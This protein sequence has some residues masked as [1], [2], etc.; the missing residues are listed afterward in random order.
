MLNKNSTYLFIILSS[1]IVFLIFEVSSVKLFAKTTL[2]EP[3]TSINIFGDT[4]PTEDMKMTLI[5]S[6]ESLKNMH[7]KEFTGYSDDEIKSISTRYLKELD[8]QRII[9]TDSEYGS[10]LSMSDK[11]KNEIM[12][13]NM[14]FAYSA[15]SLIEKKRRK[16]MH[17]TQLKINNLTKSDIEFG[18]EIIIR[19]QEDP[20]FTTDEQLKEYWFDRYQLSLIKLMAEGT[21]FDD[22]LEQTKILVSNQMKYLKTPSSMEVFDLYFNTL[23]SE[24]EAHTY[25]QSPQTEEN[26]N[27]EMRNELRGVGAVLRVEDY[28]VN[29]ESLVQG[30]PAEKSGLLLQDDR[31]IEVKHD[32][33]WVPVTGMRLNDVTSM[34]KGKPGTYAEMK[35]ARDGNPISELEV[36]KIKRDII[37]VSSM[38]LK[39]KS[40]IYSDNTYLTKNK[41]GVISIPQFYSGLTEDVL[42]MLKDLVDKGAE[43]I[44]L[45]LSNNGGGLLT[46][47]QGVASLFLDGGAI[48]Y[49]KSAKPWVTTYSDIKGDME[50]RGP[51]GIII[52]RNSASASEIVAGAIQ[53]HKRGIIL[54]ET[55]FGKG[56]VQNIYPLENIAN[57]FWIASENLGGLAMTHS[58]FYR[59]NG[60]STQMSGVS[61]D[62]FLFKHDSHKW[63]ESTYHSAIANETLPLKSSSF[64]PAHD[65]KPDNETLLKLQKKIDKAVSADPILIAFN[66]EISPE[67][68][69]R[70]SLKLSLDETFS[71]QD[72]FFDAIKD[73]VNKR[74]VTKGDK[75]VTS[76]KDIRRSLEQVKPKLGPLM[77]A[78]DDYIQ[79]IESE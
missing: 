67:K 54:G 60:V 78:F 10:L 53:D 37:N 65:A 48:V 33:E 22:A 16:L 61:P 19:E 36:I 29:V 69:S 3:A 56:T 63:G 41:I 76:I 70:K 64:R 51:L 62:L 55:S 34:I 6:F 66:Q 1:I 15:V 5:V 7:L 8:R 68:R 4:L 28:I 72:I 49:T 43:G 32:N 42:G 25:F 31:I 2:P 77:V 75:E 20:H 11:Y 27:A 52:D 79:H 17:A 9:L 47:G 74:L 38:A 44:V 50:Y 30:G 18:K 12:T 39:E 46:E 73:E 45:D 26:F 59:A 14:S 35:V 23:L 21:S 13:G 57:Y 58:M 40:K 71:E 24:I